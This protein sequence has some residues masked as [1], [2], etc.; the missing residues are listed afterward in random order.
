MEGIK[1]TSSIFF[2][3]HLIATAAFISNTAFE[4]DMDGGGRNPGHINIPQQRIWVQQIIRDFGQ[5]YTHK[6]Y[7]MT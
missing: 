4:E 3:E 6:A 1:C 2:H 7:R 5:R